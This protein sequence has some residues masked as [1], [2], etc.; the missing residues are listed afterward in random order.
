MAWR[1][2]AMAA[3]MTIAAM[4]RQ[5]AAASSGGDSVSYRGGI[6]LIAR[7]TKSSR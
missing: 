6:V 3:M 7:E 4:S 5:Y 2:K 1:G